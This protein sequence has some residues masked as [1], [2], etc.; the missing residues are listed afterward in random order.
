MRYGAVLVFSA[1]GGVI[2]GTLFMLA[3]S[4]A[5]SERT[6]STAVGWVQ[7]ISS[8]GM[9]VM[10]PLLAKLAGWAGGWHWTWLASGLASLIGLLLATGLAQSDYVSSMPEKEY[11]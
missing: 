6:V 9:F 10:P 1:V 11:L 3:V 4:I 8:M 2:P 5:P 7:Q